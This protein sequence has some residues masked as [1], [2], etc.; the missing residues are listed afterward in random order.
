MEF[1]RINKREVGQHDEGAPRTADSQL[2]TGFGTHPPKPLVQQQCR[3]LSF[4]LEL[5]VPLSSRFRD[6]HPRDW[7]PGI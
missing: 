3:D 7:L 4:N 6:V 1:H 2:L 5:G